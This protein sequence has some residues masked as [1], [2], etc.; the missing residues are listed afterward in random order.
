MGRGAIVGSTLELGMWAS[1]LEEGGIKLENGQWAI[2]V[3]FYTHCV[4]KKVSAM[5][6]HSH[7]GGSRT[8]RHNAQNTQLLHSV[9]HPLLPVYK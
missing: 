9:H 4:R 3:L 6:L 5:P 2:A 1:T 8:R 7:E